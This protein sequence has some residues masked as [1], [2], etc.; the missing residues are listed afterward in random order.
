[1]SS[2][3]YLPG[4]FEALAWRPLQFVDLP[5]TISCDLCAVVPQNI[6]RLECFHSLCEDCYR[7]IL[8]TTRQCPVD[9]QGFLESE[10]QTFPIRM[11]RLHKLHVRC[12][13]FNHGCNFV[14][15]LERMKSHFLKDCEFH[16]LT[17]KK[18]RATIPLKDIITHYMEEQCGAQNTS[19]PSDDVCID[20]S[21][22][23]IG[24][25]IN[26]S[27][28]DIADKLRAIE[29]Q[30]NIHAVGIDST[31]E[32][33]VNYAQVLRTIQDEHRLSTEGVSNL[34]STLHTVTEALSSIEDQFSNEVGRDAEVQN[35]VTSNRERLTALIELQ[36]EVAQNVVR[37][38]EGQKQC[39]E[40]LE[41]M[42]KRMQDHSS[43]TDDRL[44]SMKDILRT[45]RDSNGY[46]G[47]VAFFHVQDVDELKKKANDGETA[48]TYSDVFALCGYSVKF[49]VKFKQ[50]DGIMYIGAF[51]H[52]CR[53]T[54]DSLL[55][56]P[57]LFPYT[58]TLVHPSD[59]KKNIRHCIDVPK[60]F[61]NVPRCFNRPVESSNY[62]FGFPKLCK[63][64]D[65]VNGGF[66][67]DN[68]ITVC[69]TVVMSGM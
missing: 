26:S 67:H 47:N 66:V 25:Q 53:G 55:K 36:K 40:T 45:L 11:T 5:S 33:V 12:C 30:L 68:S 62:G 16:P 10:V 34:A 1:M 48:D 37:S 61:K 65:A 42:S 54:K 14:G 49:S 20:T 64:E 56:W 59:E 17:C 4:H 32:C 46:G 21:V 6:V 9:Q 13:N 41:G 29:D 35:I 39:S 60:A 19:C 58:L 27:L 57:F 18:C 28:S 63:L 52:I 7:S 15:S 3:S 50:Y 31:K 24:R 38:G 51:L 22:I 2:V 8:R 69:V 23:G 44:S 43:S